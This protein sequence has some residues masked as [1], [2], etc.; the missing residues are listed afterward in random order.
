MYYFSGGHTGSEQSNGGSRKLVSRDD[1]SGRVNR[2]GAVEQSSLTDGDFYPKPSRGGELHAT[3]D[4]LES[5]LLKL[6]G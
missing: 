4:D 6:N 5:A 1:P 2:F 3:V